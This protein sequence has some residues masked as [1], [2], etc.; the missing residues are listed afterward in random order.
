MA[1]TI[2]NPTI[3]FFFPALM[4]LSAS[5]DLV[6]M[7]IPNKISIAL[8]IGYLV[9]ALALG[10]PLIL[11][12]IHL[13]CGAAILALTFGLFSMGWIGG[14]DAKLAAATAVWMGWGLVLDY[15]LTAAILGGVL[16]V[17]LL[18]ARS[19]TLPLF[20]ERHEWIA[21]LHHRKSGVPYG[22]A[23][24]AAGILQYPHSPIWSAVAG[25]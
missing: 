14:G 9:A 25:V 5:M 6:T 2:I 15:G 4:A 23:L 12:L 22:I 21:R 3:L 20:L 7:T 13:S 8:A 17:I 11:I 16:T 1:S 10:T 24:A 19:L 18:F